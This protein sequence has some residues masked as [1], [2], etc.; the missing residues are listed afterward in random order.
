MLWPR[1]QKDTAT[2]SDENQASFKP[3]SCGLRKNRIC[4]SSGSLPAGCGAAESCLNGRCNTSANLNQ[5]RKEK[6][7]RIKQPKKPTII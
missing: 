3:G 4:N 1:K 5:P 6:N 7:L 2:K